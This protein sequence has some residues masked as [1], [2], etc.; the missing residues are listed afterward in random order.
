MVISLGFLIF[1]KPFLYQRKH[2]LYW[3]GMNEKNVLMIL[4]L[5]LSG[6]M[7]GLTLATPVEE[8][9][10]ERVVGVKVGD[11]VKYGDFFVTWT[12][13]DPTAQPPL[14]LIE[15]NKTEWVTNTVENISGTKITF[16]TVTHY[17]NDT[18]TTGV[19][20][21]D[22]NTGEGNGT[23]TFISANLDPNERIYSS[24]EYTHTWI[25][26]TVQLLYANAVR[27]TNYLT[28]SQYVSDEW[29]QTFGYEIQYF[30]DRTTGALSQR[31]GTSVLTT[32]EYTT[33]AMRSEVLIDTNLW[34]EKPDT[35]PPTGDA[36]P[37]QTA[38]VNQIVIFDAGNSRDNEGGWGIASYEW[39]FGDGTQ[40]TGITITHIFNAPANYTVT[41]I[42]EDWADNSGEDTLI[43]TVQEESSPPSI[44]GVVTAIILLAAGIFLWKFKTKK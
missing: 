15:H 2:G 44:M 8:N 36:G 40:G 29:G 41:L 32:G 22:I 21:V 14:D 7:P 30:W 34:E 4:L 27:E 39:D 16:Q 28:A 6:A 42:V 33:M 23:F 17:E 37:D 18:E 20:Y 1:A 31:I 13:T 25:N 10:T 9:S 43:V 11:W 35:T 12:S 19:S 5:L 24:V 3:I 38:N 26:Q